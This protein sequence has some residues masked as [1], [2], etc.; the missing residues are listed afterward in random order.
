MALL[1]AMCLF[2]HTIAGPT[3]RGGPLAILMTVNVDT[4]LSPEAVAAQPAYPG[5]VLHVDLGALA[6]NY[7]MFAKEAAPA[8]CGAA[9][10]GDAY[11]LGLDPVARALWDAGCKTFFVALTQEGLDLR[12]VLP[13]AVIYVLNGLFPGAAETLA[14]ANLQPVLSSLEEVEEWAAWCGKTGASLPAGLHIESGINRL[15]L[16]ADDVGRLVSRP[17]LLEAFTLSLVLSHLVSGD[18]PEAV[19]N[20]TQAQRFDALRAKLPPAPASLANSPGSLNGPAYRY[21]MVRVGIG[22]YGGEPHAKGPARVKP[23]VRLISHLAQV[24][25]VAAGETVG[26]GETWTAARD[27]KI[28]VIPVGYKDGYHRSL[29]SRKDL[30]DAWVSIGGH[31]APVVGRVSMDMITV[32]VTDLP[33]ELAARGTAVELFGENPTVGE[34]ATRA[35][36]ISYEV[37][38]GLGSRF[39]RVYS[40]NESL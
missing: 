36:T 22:L 17:G 16:T 14:A 26:Y 13:E 29:S 5:A 21:D 39:A 11:G 2:Q 4:E 18:S 31:R 12:A 24:R 25:N 8:E 23:V 7:S 3:G 35:G 32:D 19:I 40:P 34:I 38:T 37:F 28:A 33:D 15:G 27:S 30:P 6:Q 10:K 20:E 9:I 1:W